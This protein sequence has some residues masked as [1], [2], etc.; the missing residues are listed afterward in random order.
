VV[1]LIL[2][3]QVENN[4]L[5]PF[6]YKRTVSVPALAGIVAVLIGS[7][8]LAVLGAPLAILAA[9][10]VQILVRD[11]W[12]RRGEDIEEEPPPGRV[13]EPAG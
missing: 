3:Q 12:S 9:A 7:S 8:P 1:V 4:L 2:Y 10:A 5:Q 11:W 13:P 6:V